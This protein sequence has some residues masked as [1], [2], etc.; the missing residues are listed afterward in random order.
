MNQL[1][2]SA[3]DANDHRVVRKHQL[4][5]RKTPHQGL[6]DACVVFV[7]G[8]AG[9]GKTVWQDGY[10]MEDER[11]I[12]AT[13][14]ASTN[15]SGM[16]QKTNFVNNQLFV[17]DHSHEMTSFKQL[18]ITPTDWLRCRK[19]MFAG[20]PQEV[21]ELTCRDPN[22]FYAHLSDRMND[23][24][25][26]LYEN[27]VAKNPKM[28][29]PD[30][31]EECREFVLEEVR[32]DLDED[33]ASPDKVHRATMDYVAATTGHNRIFTHLSHDTFVYDEAGKLQPSWYIVNVC[34]YY[35]LHK[36][37]GTGVT[38][39]PTVVI[40][41][42][43]TQ[44]SVINDLCY[45]FCSH[46]VTCSHRKIPIED[47]SMITMITRHDCLLYP[48]S[49]VVKNKKHN[50]RVTGGALLPTMHLATF[51]NCL[52]RGTP[53][54]NDCLDYI[55]KH[56][57]VTRDQFLDVRGCRC[58][59]L[60]V[61][62]RACKAVLEHNTV[63]PDEE[64]RVEETMI[65]AGNA[66]PGALY[67]CLN[68][69]GAM[70][71]SANHQ[72]NRWTK[73]VV[74]KLYNPVT[75]MY[76]GIDDDAAAAADADDP[77][78]KR[79]RR[80]DVTPPECFSRYTN[81]RIFQIGRP[82]RTTHNTVAKLVRIAGS[83]NDFI[84]DMTQFENVYMDDPKIKLELVKAMAQSL[85]YARYDNDAFMQR[86]TD[87]LDTLTDEDSITQSLYD[88]R[89]V[90]TKMIADRKHDDGGGGDGATE[91]DLAYILDSAPP[92][93]MIIPK[94][95][96]VY[97]EG[98]VGATTRSPV[99]VRLGRTLFI[100][101]RQ[102]S[103]KTDCP[104]GK[105]LTVPRD[106]AQKRAQKERRWIE[107]RA[108]VNPGSKE[109]EEENSADYDPRDDFSDFDD[110]DPM[111]DVSAS[112]KS[113]GPSHLE[114]LVS[115][116][117]N[118][119]NSSSTSSSSSSNP[120]GDDDTNF[121]VVEFYPLKA[122]LVGTVTSSQGETIKTKLYVQVDQTVRAE[123]LIVMSTR[124]DNADDVKFY[125]TDPDNLVI[126]SLPK[127]ET[128]TIKQ[129]DIWSLATMGTL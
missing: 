52:E 81:V 56:M 37:F 110:D 82:Y 28:I 64:I 105:Y 29:T 128:E 19:T 87:T 124:S 73:T 102:S 79:R 54:P 120:G 74:S 96:T 91:Y 62:H 51:R 35:Y 41:G 22:T 47:L 48:N 18:K 24:C 31:Y 43:H 88:L 122:I 113:Q 100:E 123:D 109:Q 108:A 106:V 40:I 99:L 20:L 90:M 83:W 126:T 25:R 104:I 89:T 45:E 127:K 38:T 103:M 44:T 98:R 33:D 2:Y 117:N 23:V 39:K 65:A 16:Q 92:A 121:T 58:I 59:R 57:S 60:C 10:R 55:K 84:H 76:F 85:M 115:A 77:A 67:D 42:S 125:F 71:N 116:I 78:K 72:Y 8:D 95:E 112:Q 69:V 119:D 1:I 129:I 53:I 27:M 13:F 12:R 6:V 80:H 86:L 17:P 93:H 97:M 50:R 5:Y 34:F 61:T 68:S 26:F 49:F 3:I 14:C 75:K 94:G 63:S 30:Q 4:W 66:D 11:R 21:L 111:D 9:T 101:V 70:Y 7:V 46:T 15:T 107:R 118:D 114:L 36:L 32:P